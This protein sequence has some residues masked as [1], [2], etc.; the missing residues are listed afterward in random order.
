[1]RSVCFYAHFGGHCVRP[2]AYP[3]ATHT[4]RTLTETG[5]CLATFADSGVL[6]L[7]SGQVDFV[8]GRI[9][10]LPKVA[11]AVG[12]TTAIAV[13]D[14]GRCVEIHVAEKTLFCT[15]GR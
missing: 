9:S 12:E 4:W 15:L 7:Q 3:C 11:V 8:T 10:W 1:M 14:L 5:R 6:Y 13:D 2:H